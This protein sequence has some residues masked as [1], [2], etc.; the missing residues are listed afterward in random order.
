MQPAGQVGSARVRAAV[1]QGIGPLAH[2]GLDEAFSL[3]VGLGRVGSGADVAQ[4]EQTASLAEQARDI[5]R[6][7]V[8]HHPFDPDALA[9]EPAQRADQEAGGRL[10]SLVRQDLD[11]GE[12]RGVVDRDVH[13]LPA[14]L[15]VL[16][17]PIAGD[18]MAE[19]GEA[20]ELLGV[21][22]D[23]LAG[24]CAVVAPRRLARFERGQSAEAEPGQVTGHRAARQM[25]AVGDLLAGHAIRAAQPDD[26]RDPGLGQPV[27][28][29]PGRR[30]AVAQAS[31]RGLP[32]AGE[33][34]AD[35]PLT[36][37]ERFGRG[38]ACPALLEHPPDQGGSTE[39]RGAGILVRVHPGC[40]SSDGDGWHQPPDRHQPG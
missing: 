26:H 10:A 36:E 35:G 15:A 33:P 30:A 1:R 9:L 3:A 27:G 6:A 16:A 39:R 11:I 12:A 23:Q 31:Q 34:R 17:P 22:M 29:L 38:L 40:S 18:A 21:E 28:H 7:V 13:E 25:Q 4:A 24:P 20:G 2:Q 5:A 37:S 14:D 8:G 32:I 19:P